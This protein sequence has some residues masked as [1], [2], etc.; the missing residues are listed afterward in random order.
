MLGRFMLGVCVFLWVLIDLDLTA[1]W[2]SSDLNRVFT[3][4]VPRVPG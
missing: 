3:Q 1:L 4:S 2:S